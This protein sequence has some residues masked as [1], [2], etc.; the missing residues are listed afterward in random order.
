MIHKFVLGMSLVLTSAFGTC[1]DQERLQI[2]DSAPPLTL[3]KWLKGEPNPR[4][5]EGKVYVVEFGATWCPPCR[6]AIPHL[7]QLSQEYAG[8][9]T[10]ISVYAREDGTKENPGDLS[11]IDRVEYL[12]NS[13]GSKMDFAVAVDGPKQETGDA[14]KIDSVPQVF[15]VDRKGHIA[16][17]GPQEELDGVLREL[18]DGVFRPSEVAHQ[19]Q[20]FKGAVDRVLQLKKEGDYP[21]ALTQVNGL[22][23]AHPA[24]HRLYMVKYQ[25]LAGSDSAQ[26]DS[27]LQWLLITDFSGFDWDHF[28]GD[29]YTASEHPNYE[30][31]LATAD[32]AI[33]KAETKLIAALL[34][35]RKADIYLTRSRKEQGSRKGEEDVN[36]AIA[37][38]EQGLELS[39][40]TGN[41][42]DQEP[43]KQKIRELRS[44]RNSIKK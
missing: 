38:L 28:I 33:E 29:T 19:Q 39:K 8:K 42:N 41:P 18:T 36:R 15:V 10:I 35:Q 22:I 17:T 2:G 27:L 6:K 7:T 16:W 20:A 30:L 13:M 1:A 32:R 26:A 23:V 25:I 43:F 40:S 34:M 3:V 14:W 12:I 21:K 4:F 31:A 44:R 37:L 11:Y 24:D 9:L 5:E